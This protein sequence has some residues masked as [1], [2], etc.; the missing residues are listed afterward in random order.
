M[1]SDGP[2]LPVEFL[3]QAFASL[4]DEQV[5]VVL[6][7]SEDGGYYLV[8]LQRRCAALFDVEMSTSRV[9]E[10]TLA[11]ARALGMR[12]VCLSPWYDVDTVA[13][14]H[15]MAAELRTLPDC[16]AVQTRRFIREWMGHG[17]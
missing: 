1:N 5:D 8:G 6:G 12:A 17:S 2:T 15:R 14:L 9:L 3:R 4:D 16:V 10:H 11:Q 13:D 7:P